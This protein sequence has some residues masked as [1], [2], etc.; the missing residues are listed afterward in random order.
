M[1]DELSRALTPALTSLGFSPPADPF[2]RQPLRY[3]FRRVSAIGTHTFS[4]LFNKYR[5]PLFSVQLFVEPVGGLT[6]LQS[7]GGALLLG[8]LSSGSVR[9]PLGV[10]PF[11]AAPARSWFFGAR[12]ASPATAVQSV[13]ALLPEVEQWWESQRASRHILTSRTLFKGD[14]RAA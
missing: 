9:W 2:A 14:T 11:R 8:G 6:A 10:R 12:R 7:S 5:Q 13:L 3:D 1:C 4:V